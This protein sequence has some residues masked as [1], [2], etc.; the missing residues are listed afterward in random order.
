[1]LIG[2]E[3]PA[4]ARGAVLGTF[5]LCGAC[6][7]MLLTFAGGVVFDRFGPTAPFIMMAVI[8]FAVLAGALALRSRTGAQFLRQ[9]G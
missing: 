9:R 3:A 5:S 2:Q 7:I 1:V 8:N 4:E 6:G